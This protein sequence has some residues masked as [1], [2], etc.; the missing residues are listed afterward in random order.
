[1]ATSVSDRA[2]APMVCFF[3]V[4]GE[5]YFAESFRDHVDFVTW[6]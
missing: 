3:I 2:N 6:R 1:M 4:A 5:A